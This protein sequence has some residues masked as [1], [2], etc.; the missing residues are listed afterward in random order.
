MFNVGGPYGNKRDLY[1]LSSIIDAVLAREPIVLRARHRVV[2][3]YVH[4]EQLVAMLLEL[5]NPAQTP[6]ISACSTPAGAEVIELGDLAER[7]RRRWSATAPHRPS[8]GVSKWN[9]RK[10]GM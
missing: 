6:P 9:C 4:V 1:A 5:V 2:R 3:S 8:N 7:I 10:I